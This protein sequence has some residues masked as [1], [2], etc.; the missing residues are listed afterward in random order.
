V[1]VIS[2]TG[3]LVD[4]VKTNNAK[5]IVRGMR[6]VT[7]FE[8]EYAMALMNKNLGKEVETVF[9]TASEGN[10]FVSS[11]IIKEV[12]KLGGDVSNKIPACVFKA[13]QKKFPQS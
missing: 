13:L 5:V 11:S 7:D 8:Y 6:A 1:E 2:F 9:L 12:F 4:F 10:T 3:L